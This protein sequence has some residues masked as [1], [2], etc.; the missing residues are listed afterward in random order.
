[1]ARIL[2]IG[3]ACLGSTV[4][5]VLIDRGLALAG[6][7]YSA[8]PYASIGDNLLAALALTLIL[9]P[10]LSRLPETGARPVL[11]ASFVS[12]IPMF[13]V[14][15]L[16]Y[17]SGKELSPQSI[18]AQSLWFSLIGAGT[19]AGQRMLRSVLHKGRSAS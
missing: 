1:M 11:I 4:I 8:Y 18:L 7:P 6:N 16:A 3:L 12:L 15:A 19:A 14:V 13:V 9:I 5:V 2:E 17:G 10:V